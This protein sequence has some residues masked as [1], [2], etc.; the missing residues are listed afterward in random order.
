MILAAL[1]LIPIHCQ[2]VQSDF[3][4][5]EA[6]V[7]RWQ[8]RA[9]NEQGELVAYGPVRFRAVIPKNL[10]AKS[11]RPIWTLHGTRK[12][13]ELFPGKYGPHSEARDKLEIG[14]VVDKDGTF[15]ADMSEGWSDHNI[16]LQGTLRKGKIAGTWVWNTF[17]GG[18]ARGT[19]TLTRLP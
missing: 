10:P 1:A 7:G 11:A 15:H 19:F 4:K 14:A 17:A 3:R 2:A 8:Y 6:L 13:K 12:V 16:I 18:R 9:L 5:S